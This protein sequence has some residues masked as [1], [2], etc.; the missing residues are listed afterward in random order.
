MLTGEARHRCTLYSLQTLNSFTT[1]VGLFPRGVGL[2]LPVWVVRG[3]W[4]G[5]VRDILAIL[6]SFTSGVGLV[7]RGVGLNLPVH[8]SRVCLVTCRVV[9]LNSLVGNFPLLDGGLDDEKNDDW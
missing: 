5:R 9:G 4:L 3:V 7:P 2:N 6:L 1:G 8:I